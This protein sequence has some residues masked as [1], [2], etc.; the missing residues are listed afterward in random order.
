MGA[1]SWSA[2]AK[3]RKMGPR[4]RAVYKAR[5]PGAFGVSRSPYYQS[6][7]TYQRRL[8]REDRGISRLLDLRYTDPTY[9]AVYWEQIQRAIGRLFAR[10]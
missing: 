10:K 7:K 2:I 6:S 5:N 9:A 8:S 3:L 4:E 1:D